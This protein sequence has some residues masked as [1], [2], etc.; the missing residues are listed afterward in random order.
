MAHN[1]SCFTRQFIFD[2]QGTHLILRANL[3]RFSIALTMEKLKNNSMERF[4]ERLSD[5]KKSTHAAFNDASC[6]FVHDMIAFQI[7]LDIL[8]HFRK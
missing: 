1:S 2:K 7:S 5:A 4:R 6:F 8:S 3:E